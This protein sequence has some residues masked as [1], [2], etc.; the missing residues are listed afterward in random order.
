[1]NFGIILDVTHEENAS[2]DI[3]EVY[4]DVIKKIVGVKEIELAAHILGV[5]AG[6]ED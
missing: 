5:K 6:H 3:K 2:A 4:C 1:V